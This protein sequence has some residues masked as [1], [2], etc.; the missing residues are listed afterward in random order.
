M[1]SI[2]KHGILTPPLL[3]QR[4]PRPKC[5]HISSTL[6]PLFQ[7]LLWR[8]KVHENQVVRTDP[9][10]VEVIVYVRSSSFVPFVN[11]T[12]VASLRNFTVTFTNVVLGICGLAD[13]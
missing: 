3:N 6:F 7:S 11:Q 8:L 2:Q 13:K 1:T 9:P 10:L 12:G 4:T 5:C